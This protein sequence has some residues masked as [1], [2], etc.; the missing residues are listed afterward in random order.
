MNQDIIINL[1]GLPKDITIGDLNQKYN[2]LP[3]RDSGR[4]NSIPTQ[5]SFIHE[6]LVR[7]Y[8]LPECTFKFVYIRNKEKTAQD[9][10]DEIEN[11]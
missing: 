11:E 3:Q 2:A 4:G 10:L 7:H 1:K 6:S 5:S 9:I 8:F